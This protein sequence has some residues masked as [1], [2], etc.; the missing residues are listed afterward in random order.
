MDDLLTREEFDAAM[1]PH[2]VPGA[3]ITVMD[4]N[5]VIWARHWGLRSAVTEL[6]V[7]AGTLFQ[8]CSMTKTVNGLLFMLLAADGS[9]D[10]DAP[11]NEYLADW[12]L[13]G[14][15]AD[16]VTIAMLLAHTGGTSLYGFWGYTQGVPIPTL[17]QILDGLPPANSLPVRIVRKPGTEI[18]Y[19]GGGTTVLQKLAQDVTGDDYA[20]LVQRRIL[21]PLGMRN[22][23]MAMPPPSSFT[24]LALGHRDG[25]QVRGGYC[26]HPE[27]ASAGLWAT[28]ADYALFLAALADAV[29]G[30][31]GS[32]IPKDLARRMIT[33]PFGDAALGCFSQEPGIINHAGGGVGYRTHYVADLGR[34]R[35]IISLSNGEEGAPPLRALRQT[36]CD[37]LGWHLPGDPP[38]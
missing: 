15:D 34:G 10:L 29:A 18:S 38:A 4:A 12:K 20:Q 19:S 28:G 14:T 23:A 8:T 21:E 24:N 16:S 27:L 33:P 37:R 36:I 1:G 31:P 13:Q 17:E 30:R 32:I 25:V 6:P 22:A 35:G 2:R 7:D 26:L 5:R 11:A 3:S 9:I